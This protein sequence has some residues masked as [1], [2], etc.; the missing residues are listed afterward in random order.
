MRSSCPSGQVPVHRWFR[1]PLPPAA[2]RAKTE[3]QHESSDSG[4]GERSR[5]AGPDGPITPQST[6]FGSTQLLTYALL[7]T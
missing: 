4:H 5:R 7:R 1:I 6:S 3:D 2:G